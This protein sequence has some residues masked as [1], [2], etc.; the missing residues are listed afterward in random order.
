MIINNSMEFKGPLTSSEVQ[1]V[2]SESDILVHVESMD[3]VNRCL[4]R[5]SMSTK[6]PQYLSSGKCILAVGPEEVSSIRYLEEHKA[7][8]VITDLQILKQELSKLIA[9]YELRRRYAI[10]ALKLAQDSHN[11]EK[12]HQRFLSLVRKIIERKEG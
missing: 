1:S 3:K 12:N 7:G 2:I 6:I 9:D 5:L 8:M 11:P 10:N 4:T